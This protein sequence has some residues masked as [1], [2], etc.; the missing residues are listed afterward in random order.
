[1]QTKLT[2]RKNMRVRLSNIGRHTVVKLRV[3][4]TVSQVS[5]LPACFINVFIP[6]MQLP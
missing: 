4:F 5:V 3:F 1:M 2:Q 6:I